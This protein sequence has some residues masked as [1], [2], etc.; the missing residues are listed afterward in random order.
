MCRPYKIE[1]DSVVKVKRKEVEGLF[2]IKKGR[3]HKYSALLEMK[4][5]ISDPTKLF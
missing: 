2:S 4:N 1:N 5:Y 3:I